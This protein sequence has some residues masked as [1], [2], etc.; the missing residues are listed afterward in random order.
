M[1]RHPYPWNSALAA[2]SIGLILAG[3]VAASPTAPTTGPFDLDGPLASGGLRVRLVSHGRTV[4]TVPNTWTAARFTLSNP[5]LLTGDR[6]ETI[7]KA[8]FNDI[9]GGSASTTTTLFSSARA[10]SYSLFASTYNNS[11][12]NAVGYASVDLA[13]GS[14]TGATITLRTLPEW[15]AGT[16]AN[17]AGTATFAGDAGVPAAAGF[18]GPKGIAFGGDGSMYICD[19]GNDRVRKI[20]AAQTTVTTL[21]GDGTSATLDNPSALAYDADR[22]VLFIADTSN[23]RIRFVTSLGTAP[24]VSGTTL[25][26]AAQPQALAY[27]PSRD[28]LYVA[29]S[30]HTVVSIDAPSIM[31]GTP[32][33]I[34]GTG[35]AGDTSGTAMGTSVQL[36]SPQGLAID[37]TGTY[38]YVADTGNRKIRRVTLGS[39]TTSTLA[40]TGTD[41]S[42]GDGTLAASAS[43]KAPAALAFDSTD[44]GRLFVLDTGAY[45]VRAITLGN[46]MIATVFGNGTSAYAGDGQGAQQA[47]LFAPAGLGLSGAGGSLFVSESG[48]NGHRI[49]SAQ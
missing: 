26:L 37:D 12:R 19:A 45:V 6:T 15:T 32:N 3:C 9:G 27:D 49:R 1:T 16:L 7:A 42:A 33:V 17:A 18:N 47:S 34:V 35:T 23:Q 28:A 29:L 46:G 11:V 38:L 44:G 8:S 24:T 10:G 13:A 30:N 5:T 40:G 41:A 36:N 2:G 43:F 20:D 25:L 22:D 21:V 39:G 48:T 14:S 4:Q 31:A